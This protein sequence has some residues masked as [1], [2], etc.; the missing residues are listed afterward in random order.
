MGTDR[1]SRLLV[2][3]SLPAT[4][5]ML[6]MASYNIADTIFVGRLG[7]EALAAL[8]VAFPVQMLFGSVGIGTGVG[9]GSLIAR[10]LGA[11]DRRAAARTAGQVFFLTGLFGILTAG[12]GLAFLEPLL[13]AFGA[14]PEIL[15][16][17]MQ[18]MQVVI[19]GSVF[20]FGMMMMNNAVRSEGNPVYSMN[21]MIFSSVFNIAIDP[22]FIFALGM[23][24][25]GAAVATV[26]AKV[27][28]FAI[29]LHYYVSGK[30]AFRIGTM[31][32]R[33]H[34]QTIVEIYRVGLPSLLM[35]LATNLSLVV[36]NNL[37]GVFGFIPIAVMGLI[38]RL[39]QFAFMPVIGVAQG[40]LPIIGYNYGAGQ[41]GRIREALLKGGA[42]GTLFMTVMGVLFF[43]FPTVA[44]GIFTDDPAIL[45][46][47]IGALRYMVLAYPLIAGIMVSRTL[48]QAIGRGLPALFLALLREVI[49]YIPLVL[50][51]PRF[52]D[53][54]GIWASRPAADV[55]TFVVSAAVVAREFWRRGFSLTGGAVAGAAPQGAVPSNAVV[56]QAAGD[57]AND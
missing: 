29:L 5:A 39:Q 16:Q 24:I 36:V 52:L 44:L 37:L 32:L 40:L 21:A 22:L 4:I 56:E 43:A 55:L 28:G 46:M 2:R 51:L 3:F 15:P 13:V 26:I 25:R 34:V 19:M 27:L 53:L 45:D 12:L 11:G 10:S 35:M 41:Y 30:S 57:D 1:I 48:F 54:T 17:T 14:T 38:M 18:Y 49:L 20:L 42:A 6:V 9:A 33:P 8:S 50:V 23:G 47:G 7:S 31:D